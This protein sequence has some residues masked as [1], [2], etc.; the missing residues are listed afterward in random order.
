MQ[1][2]LLMYTKTNI[3]IYLY[4]TNY[5]SGFTDSMDKLWEMVK[6]R[7]AW[8]TA[9]HG[10]AKSWLQLSKREYIGTT[11]HTLFCIFFLTYMY[12]SLSLMILPNQYFQIYFH[13]FLMAMQHFIVKC[14]K[15]YLPFRNTEAVSSSLLLQ[16]KLQTNRKDTLQAKIS[17]GRTYLSETM[18]PHSLLISLK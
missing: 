12:F 3:F 15:H 9:V 11:L 13:Y 17:P 6:D 10:V 14:A 18:Y 1:K 7:E 2:W 8:C 5:N 16:R 4:H